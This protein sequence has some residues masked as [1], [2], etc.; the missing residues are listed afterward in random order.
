M[1]NSGTEVV[2]STTITIPYAP[3]CIEYVV[4][5]PHYLRNRTNTVTK[6]CINQSI[7]SNGVLIN[8]ATI[9]VN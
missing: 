8:E 2:V 9:L 4:K 1:A 7:P 6:E 5:T 3:G